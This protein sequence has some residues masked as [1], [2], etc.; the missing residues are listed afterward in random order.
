MELRA[1]RYFVT[2]AEELHFGRAAERLHVVQPAVSRQIARFERELGTTLLDRSPRHVRL[3]PAG[4]RVLGAA[5]D[6]LAAADRVRAV[7]GQPGTTLRIGTAPGLAMRLERA[8]EVLARDRPGLE[9]ILL[10]LPP[11]ARLDAVREGRLDVALV[12]GA[13]AVAGLTVLTRW[14]EPLHAV[15]ADNHPLAG[16]E[17]VTLPEL[18]GGPLRMLCDDADAALHGAI[19]QTLREADVCPTPGRTLGSV[20]DLVVA[21]GAEPGAWTLLPAELVGTSGSRRIRSLPLVPP[22]TMEASVVASSNTPAA[23]LPALAEAFAD[24]RRAA[25]K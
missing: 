11:A 10:D 23:C 18:V 16:R 9:T 22:R 19:L 4:E 3:T 7:A 15:I 14:A 5:R 8:I 6:A 12:R 2:V 25:G 21:V 13:C 1:L 24:E 17:T 20:Q